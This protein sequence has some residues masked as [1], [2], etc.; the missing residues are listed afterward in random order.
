MR[1]T[2]VAAGL[3][4]ALCCV[5]A[6][7]ADPNGTRNGAVAGAVVGHEATKHHHAYRHHYHHR[8]HGSAPAA[9]QPD[10]ATQNTA[11]PH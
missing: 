2:I 5:G 10:P 3:L 4:A 6:A 8:H 1:T 9:T 7:N 11:P